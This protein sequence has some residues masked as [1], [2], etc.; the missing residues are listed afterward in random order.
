MMTMG[1][2]VCSQESTKLGKGI[3]IAEA[4]WEKLRTRDTPAIAPKYLRSFR[5][6]RGVL[7][8]PFGST[9]IPSQ[10]DVKSPTRCREGLDPG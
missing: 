10:P 8:A 9:R 4:E 7:C 2:L 3:K 1:V 6:E 5:Q